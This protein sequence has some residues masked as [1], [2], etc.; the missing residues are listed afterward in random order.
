[1]AYNR[2]AKGSKTCGTSI[3]RKPSF[4]NRLEAFVFVLLQSN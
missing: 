2:G 3:S 1:V 4:V